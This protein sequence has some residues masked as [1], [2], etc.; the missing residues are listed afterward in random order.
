MSTNSNIPEIEVKNLTIGYDS[1]VIL[2]DLNFTINQGEIVAIM[3]GSGCGKSTLLKRIIGLVPPMSGDILIRGKS[4]VNCTPEEKR[5]I[6]RSFGVTYQGGALFGSMTVGEN[7]ALPLEEYTNYS[8][9]EIAAIVKEKLSLVDL[10]NYESYMPSELS[11]G[12][13]KRAGLA[14]ALA[15]NP[16]LLFFD[17]PSAGLDPITSAHLDK[18]ILSLK[19]RFNVT[20]VIVSHELDSIFTVADRAIMLDKETKTI[21]EIGTPEDMKNNSSI[22]WVRE[23]LNRAG[24]K[25]KE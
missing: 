13:C 12:M 3:G 5:K 11:G 23:F 16:T 8:K 6:M 4:I 20:V 14:R 2:K 1:R 19:D 22:P 18:L 21:A 9:K 25:R 15:L 17:E 10:A 24:L 7:V